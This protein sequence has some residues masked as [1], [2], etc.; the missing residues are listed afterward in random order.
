[1]CGICTPTFN[2][3]HLW[4]FVKFKKI[5]I[6]E[7]DLHNNVSFYFHPSNKCLLGFNAYKCVCNIAL[8]RYSTFGSQIY[9]VAIVKKQLL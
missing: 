6:P 3:R 8:Y 7:E 2:R 1:M 9:S 5:Y 4:F